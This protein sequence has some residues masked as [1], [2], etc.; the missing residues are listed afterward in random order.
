MKAIIT[1]QELEQMHLSESEFRLEVAVRLYE[2]KK[3]S[4]GLAARFARMNR[5]AFQEELANRRIPVHYT[6]QDLHHDLDVL[7]S[8]NEKE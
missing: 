8:I 7:K 1:D 2:L 6:V 4:L 3:L 5:Y